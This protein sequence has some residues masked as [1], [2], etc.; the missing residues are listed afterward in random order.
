MNVLRADIAYTLE[1]LSGSTSYKNWSFLKNK[2]KLKIMQ[3]W[4]IVVY[5]FK[6]I[7]FSV[8]LFMEC[9]FF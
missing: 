5:S 2:I 8:A 7:P 4:K 1:F 6:P 3:I 9:V